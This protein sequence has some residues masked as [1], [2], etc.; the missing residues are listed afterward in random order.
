MPI[1]FSL[2]TILMTV[3]FLCVSVA[4]NLVI[5]SPDNAAF[6]SAESKWLKLANFII[7]IAAVI[8]IRT[9]G[10]IV[11]WYAL[12]AFIAATSIAAISRHF[13]LLS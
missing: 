1:K 3:T 6:A 2:E 9:A 13:Q 7:F 12:F 5:Q 8:W 10:K 4:G 11:I